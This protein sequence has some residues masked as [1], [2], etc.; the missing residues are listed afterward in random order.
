MIAPFIGNHEMR[1]RSG[2]PFC[3]R[4][5]TGLTDSY[6]FPYPEALLASVNSVNP[7]VT[8]WD[9]LWKTMDF[10]R[11]VKIVAV[12]KRILNKPQHLIILVGPLSTNTAG[13]PVIGSFAVPF[14]FGLFLLR[15][16][17]RRKPLDLDVAIF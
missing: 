2:S 8:P 7:H 13:R 9:S 15:N 6:N 11:T 1:S 17:V 3:G 16:L 5:F 4:Q 14:L 10:E 12:A